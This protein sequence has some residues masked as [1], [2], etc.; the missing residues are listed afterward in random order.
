MVT[1]DS[2]GHREVISDQTNYLIFLAKNKN[3]CQL[4]NCDTCEFF[5]II[6]EILINQ[7]MGV[8][9]RNFVPY[10]GFD[11]TCWIVDLVNFLIFKYI[12]ALHP[13]LNHVNSRTSLKFQKTTPAKYN[14]NW[15]L[16]RGDC[17]RL[18]IRQRCTQCSKMRKIAQ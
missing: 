17:R 9:W 16:E 18:K 10:W 7:Y 12:Y 8:I 1:T 15:D 5:Y 2:S 11:S 4:A 13:E 3:K 6:F 14:G